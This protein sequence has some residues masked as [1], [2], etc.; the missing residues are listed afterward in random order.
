MI[1][2]KSIGIILFLIVFA[3]VTPL[4]VLASDNSIT[5][6]QLEN[7]FAGHCPSSTHGEVISCADALPYLNAAIQK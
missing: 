3:L 2:P 7:A 1:L 4:S 5:L 6:D